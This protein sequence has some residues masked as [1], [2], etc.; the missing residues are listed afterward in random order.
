MRNILSATVALLLVS[1]FMLP[2]MIVSPAAAIELTGTIII[3]K[4]TIPSSTTSFGFTDNITAPNSFSL[5]HGDTITFNDV[6]PGTYIVTEDDPGPF[7]ALTGM[8]CL[9]PDGGSGANVATR[10]ATIDLDPGETVE[11]SFENDLQTGTIIINKFTIPSST[12]SFGFTDNITAP[13]SFSLAHGDTITFNDVLPGTYI[14][15]EDDPG[16]FYALTGMACLDPD[17]GSGA[18]VATR[19]ATI[20]LDPGETVECSF[21]N[22]LQTGTITAHKFNDL[23]GNGVQDAGEEDLSGWLMTLYA[24]PSCGGFEMASGMTNSNGNVIFSNVEAGD[25]SVQ[26]LPLLGWQNTTPICQDVTLPPGGSEI[27]SFGNQE[28]APVTCIELLKTGPE[29]AS[30][31]E[32]ITYHFQVRNCGEVTLADGVQVYD[33]LFGSSPIWSGDLEPGDIHEFDRTYALPGDQ[34]G[35]F[36]ND[37]W[38]IG[39]PLGPEGYLPAVQDDDS[40]TVTIIC[41]ADADGDGV[42]DPDDNCVDTY[43]PGQ[44][45]GDGD[46]VGDVCD[47]CVDTPNPDQADADMDGVGDVCD[48]CVDTPNPGQEDADMDGVGGAC[49]NCVDTPNPDQADADMDGVGD[50]C[51]PDADGDGHD[52]IAHGGDDCDDADSSIHPGAPEICGDGIDQDCDGYDIICIAVDIKPASCPNPL[53]V[54]DKGVLP[55]AILGSEVFDATEVDPAAVLLAGVAPLR[56]ALEDMAGPQCSGP[57]GYLDLTLKFKT[58][59]IVAALGDVHDGDVLT[60]MLT[61]NLFDGTPILGDDEVWIIARRWRSSWLSNILAFAKGV[62]SGTPFLFSGI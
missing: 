16:P 41:C 18:N 9:D 32:T 34:C 55:V 28:E 8:A 17:G 50:A 40:W 31:G 61:G 2:G 25:Y 60:L 52:A 54:G 47:N 57:D 1:A 11:C 5:A 59:E 42:C 27:V 14:V 23:N 4:F 48:N 15:T 29:A 19:T 56:W 44:E 12:T 24:G 3:N 38:A 39:S 49:D 58:Q 21:E 43:N 13:N 36:T 62:S 7:Y 46:G 6:L 37:A 53:N 51:D 45:D 33:P 20:D 10:T 22:D 30:P 26:E 35:D